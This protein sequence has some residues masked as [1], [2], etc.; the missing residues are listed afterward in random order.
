MGAYEMI[1]NE[2]STTANLPFF[3]AVN[4]GK[5]DKINLLEAFESRKLLPSLL[6]TVSDI[7]IISENG[8]AEKMAH[9]ITSAVDRAMG[10]HLTGLKSYFGSK[11]ERVSHNGM[12]IEYTRSQTKIIKLYEQ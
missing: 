9:T 3:K 5:Y 7:Q 12:I 4:A 2:A 6:G 1:I 8:S 10:A 11:P